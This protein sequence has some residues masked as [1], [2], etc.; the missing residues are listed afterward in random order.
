MVDILMATYNGEKYLSQ[1]IESIL[2][3]SYKNI[4]LIIRDDGSNDQTRSIIESYRVKYPQIIE[5]ISDTKNIKSAAGNF[6]ELSKYASSEYVM[7]SDQDDVWDKDKVK[8]S[9][10]AIKSVE[11]RLGSSKP[12]LVFCRYRVV[13]EE[14]NQLVAE[15]DVDINKLK[16]NRLI[17]QN[18]IAGCVSIINKSLNS[19]IGD[20]DNLIMMHDWWIALI[21]CALGVIEYLPETLVLYRQHGANCIGNVDTSSLTYNASIIKNGTAKE[22]QLRYRD[23]IKLFES[24]YSE[25][26]DEDKKRIIDGYIHLF[27]LNKIA[28]IK[29]LIKGRYFKDT[30]LRI[31]GQ[32][33]FI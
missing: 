18:C 32:L 26:L 25:L 9:V 27:S 2:N 1:Q 33:M 7:F 21:A 10:E 19:I 20:Y 14:L 15:T 17:V 16:L 28:R 11:S 13:D 29:E 30:M 31:I 4:R 8:K 3:Q 12:I 6:M 23:Q 5:I 24:R 22:L